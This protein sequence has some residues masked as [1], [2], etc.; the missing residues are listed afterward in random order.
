MRAELH[1]QLCAPGEL[2]RPLACSADEL[3]D[4]SGSEAACAGAGA[5]PVAPLP[6]KVRKV[7][8]GKEL[9]PDLGL[10]YWPLTCAVRNILVAVGRRGRAVVVAT[11]VV[12]IGL[13]RVTVIRLRD[14]PVHDRGFA[15]AHG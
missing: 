14:I 5:D 3:G 10:D 1:D 12:G 8:I 9:S 15:S 7:R 4:S 13:R 11:I 6:L 2:Y